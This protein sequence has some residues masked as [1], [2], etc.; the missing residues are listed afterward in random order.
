MRVII[1][2]IKIKCIYSLFK[3]HKC[4]NLIQDNNTV[5]L[6]QELTMK[7]DKC[8]AHICIYTKKIQ[9][10]QHENECQHFAASL[11]CTA[12]AIFL[13]K[14]IALLI[15]GNAKLWTGSNLYIKS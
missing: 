15:L 1:S 3:Q 9:I 12:T 8:L 10:Q 5:C 7:S 14:H 13:L 4:V 2:L 11:L 6:R